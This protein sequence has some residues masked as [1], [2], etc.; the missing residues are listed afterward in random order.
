MPNID[1]CYGKPVGTM[2]RVANGYYEAANEDINGRDCSWKHC[3][4]EFCKARNERPC[5]DDKKD[6][7]S[8]HLAFY[9]ASWG[10]Y[11]GSTFLLQK[12]YKIHR[13]VVDIIMETKYDPLNGITWGDL[14]NDEYLDL[15]F[16]LS[17]NNN[18]R[19]A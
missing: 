2:T 13:P 5:T 6:C 8:L 17:N 9:L 4:S 12:D 14:T 19:K 10:M 11:R 18:S 1:Y 15:L 3:Y 7:L 16:D